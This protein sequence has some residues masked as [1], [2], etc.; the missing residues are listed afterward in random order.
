MEFNGAER[1]FKLL[2]FTD[3]ANVP[4]HHYMAGVD[5][6]LPAKGAK[7]ERA[8]AAMVHAMIELHKVLVAKIVERKNAEPKLVTLHPHIS[9]KQ[10]LLY[11]V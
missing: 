10:P 1:Q 5:V 2:G 8:F 6:V 4:R 9:K 3:A 11:L 7:N